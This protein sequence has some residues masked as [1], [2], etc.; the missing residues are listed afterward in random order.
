MKK[1][2][3][4]WMGTEPLKNR[5]RFRVVD[6]GPPRTDRTGDVPF[7]VEKHLGYDMMKMPNW[8]P[9][10]EGQAAQY[11]L[12]ALSHALG[13]LLTVDPK[14][15]NLDHPLFCELNMAVAEGRESKGCDCDRPA[16][17]VAPK[18]DE[19]KPEDKYIYVYVWDSATFEYLCMDRMRLITLPNASCATRGEFGNKITWH[20]RQ[21][22]IL[23]NRELGNSSE[24]V[25]IQL[26]PVTIVQFS[27]W[28]MPGDPNNPL[29]MAQRR[30]DSH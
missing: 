1:P 16:D 11:A 9:V 12:W 23:Q 8:G 26:S 15:L 6:R 13:Q 22:L 30:L 18:T 27:N 5:G 2:M 17:P 7:S 25:V 24:A 19:S 3:V 10:P 29:E 20:N 14:K 28:S 21:V 4:I